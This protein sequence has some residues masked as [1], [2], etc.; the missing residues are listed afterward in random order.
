MVGASLE[1]GD[2]VVSD[3]G[4]VGG[5]VCVVGETCRVADGVAWQSKT[6]LE[7]LGWG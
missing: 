1:P 5:E 3:I 6:A 7:G 2:E 4:G